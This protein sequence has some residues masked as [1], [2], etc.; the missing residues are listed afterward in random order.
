ME[1]IKRLLEVL[2]TITDESQSG[3]LKKCYEFSFDPNRGD[4][5]LDES[6]LNLNQSRDIIKDAIEKNK[7]TQFPLTVQKTILQDLE[8]II[9]FQSNLVSGADHVVN[10]VDAIELLHFDIWR[11]GFHNLSGEVLGYTN[12]MNQLKEQEVKIKQLR[13]ELDNGLHLRGELEKLLTE[14]QKSSTYL[15]SLV[16]TSQT[17][18]DS[19]KENLDKS[20]EASQKAAAHLATIQQNDITATQLLSSSV[21]SNSEIITFEERIREFFTG[22]ESYQK[23]IDSISEQAKKNIE[24]N[25]KETDD[26]VNSLKG[27]QDQIKDQ[28]QKATGFSL[29]H[30]F[31]TRQDKLKDSKNF[32]LMA[33]AFVIISSLLL[34][35]LIAYTTENIDL[36]FYL[37]LSISVPIIYAVAFCSAQYTR[38]RKL[39]EEY[40]FKSNIS[41]SL[42]PYKEL[43]E[44]LVV[45]ATPQEREQFI[46]FLIDSIGKV[47]T[48]PTSKVFGQNQ[49]DVRP[50]IALKELGKQLETVIKPFVSILKVIRPN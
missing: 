6:F 9:D 25:K 7:L 20:I 21:S 22:I 33:L 47:F 41:I 50:D 37:K 35:G 5:T 24:G 32:W 46:T 27:L 48:S 43:V 36:A 10:L 15:Q 38:E 49:S 2:N 30:S 42:I 40:A 16:I 3:V 11:F 18:N 12:K 19:I 14:T 13:K 23:K 26:L 44:K 4:I 34:T 31:Q 39:E 45:D 8:S 29:F 1:I 17:G 28:L